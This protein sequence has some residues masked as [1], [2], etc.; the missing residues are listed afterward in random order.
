MSEINNNKAES[1]KLEQDSKVA[2]SQNK[3]DYF[4]LFLKNDKKALNAEQVYSVVELT[5]DGDFALQPKDAYWGSDAIKN[6][7]YK[8]DKKAFDKDYA[9]AQNNFS[10]FESVQE[11]LNKLTRT[12]SL[13]SYNSRSIS[14]DEYVGRGM[15]LNTLQ[16]SAAASKLN[17][18]DWQV[19]K[20]PTVTLKKLG[21]WMGEKLSDGTYKDAPGMWEQ[22][23]STDMHRLARTVNEDGTSSLKLS[24]GT[25][26]LERFKGDEAFHS[27]DQLLSI[28]NS[29]ILEN[30]WMDGNVVED[31]WYKVA[32]R[33]VHKVIPYTRVI[34]FVASAVTGVA[35][36][37]KTI[38]GID[39]E[40]SGVSSAAN[41]IQNFI[42]KFDYDTS[43]YAK[44]HRYSAES[45]ISG[46]MDIV[47][48][49]FGMGAVSKGVSWSAS[50]L[51]TKIGSKS[52]LKN[53]GKIGSSAGKHS[54][55]LFAGE[56]IGREAKEMGLDPVEAAAIHVAFTAF[57]YTL[58]AKLTESILG[59][60][61]GTSLKAE[62][63]QIQRDAIKST[64]GK[65][66]DKAVK[67]T[68]E[69]I[70]KIMFNKV[71]AAGTKLVEMSSRAGEKGVMGYAGATINESLEESL[72]QSGEDGLKWLFNNVYADKLQSDENR[73][74]GKG[75][76]YDRTW[77]DFTDDLVYSALL[78]GFGGTMGKALH[79]IESRRKGDE[80]KQRTRDMVDFIADPELRDKFEKNL[81]K[82][83]LSEYGDTKTTYNI[84]D[85]SV[86]AVDPN[87]PNHL[88]KYS[89][90]EINKQAFMEHYHNIKSIYDN[91]IKEVT[92]S[93]DVNKW[94]KAMEGRYGDQ[95]RLSYTN[96]QRDVNDKI[97]SL[98]D[99]TI[100][101]DEARKELKNAKD[102]D[103]KN[104]AKAKLD[105][106]NEQT[107]EIKEGIRKIT[108][109][110][111]SNYYL[112]DAL[113]AVN[114]SINISE[115]GDSLSEDHPAY[116]PFDSNDPKKYG[117]TQMN[118]RTDK[119]VQNE[120]QRMSDMKE[121]SRDITSQ[122]LATENTDEINKLVASGKVT[123]E[124]SKKIINHVS[125][126]ADP[127]FDAKK[128]K[129]RGIV[130]DYL[131]F[132]SDGPSATAVVDG[133]RTKVMAD[134]EAAKT[135]DDIKKIY[136]DD[137]DELLNT[138]MLTDVLED[139]GA[140]DLNTF[141]TPDLLKLNK[142][143]YIEHNRIDKI[144]ENILS[145]FDTTESFEELFQ[146][147]GKSAGL[148]Y[149][150][151]H[152]QAKQQAAEE[153][154]PVKAQ[155]LLLKAEEY[156]SIYEDLS[157]NYSSDRPEAVMESIM[158]RVQQIRGLKSVGPNV[159]SY[160]KQH[161]HKIPFSYEAKTAYSENTMKLISD[162]EKSSNI[163]EQNKIF[164]ELEKSIEIDQERL[165]NIEKELINLYSTFAGLKHISDTNGKNIVKN[166]KVAA[167]KLIAEQ[168]KLLHESILIRIDSDELGDSVSDLL[169]IAMNSDVFE[170][171]Y[172]SLK[173]AEQLINRH[174]ATL[175]QE[176]RD[177]IVSTFPKFAYGS[178][179]ESISEY[180][181][182][183]TITREGYADFHE[184]F[185]E[186]LEKMD[187]APTYEQEKIIAQ[188]VSKLG[189]VSNENKFLS[190]YALSQGQKDA[191]Q[192]LSD[193][194]FLDAVGGF[195]KT[196]YVAAVASAVVV[197]NIM[198]KKAAQDGSSGDVIVASPKVEQ[199]N[200]L[201]AS[202]EKRGV[203][204]AVGMTTNES[205]SPDAKTLISDLKDKAKYL[206][207]ASMI[208]YDEATYISSKDA[209][210]LNRAIQE[211]NSTE[212]EGKLPLRVLLMG[213]TSQM[214]NLTAITPTV[215][216]LDNVGD[217]QL[218]ERT[219]KGVSSQRSSNYQ[220]TDFQ[221][222][223]GAV[224][225]PVSDNIPIVG[226]WGRDHKGELGGF[227]V[228]T[229]KDNV[230][231]EVKSLMEEAK[232]AGK[233]FKYIT[234]K[235]KTD[236][237]IAD[238]ISAMPE[239]ANM[240]YNIEDVQGSEADYVYV[241]FKNTDVLVNQGPHNQINHKKLY[242]A[243][244]RAHDFVMVAPMGN[245]KWTSEQGKI[246][247]SDTRIQPEH[248]QELKDSRMEALSRINLP[249]KTVIPE[250]EPK[251]FKTDG[252]V[253]PSQG[254]DIRSRNKY[255]SRLSRT[256][257]KLKGEKSEK[258]LDYSSMQKP[259]YEQEYRDAFARYVIDNNIESNQEN[260][261]KFLGEVS[262][263]IAIL[264][265]DSGFANYTD[266]YMSENFPLLSLFSD[267]V[268]KFL[269]NNIHGY[270]KLNYSVS[271]GT[272]DA[273]TLKNA[274]VNYLGKKGFK[275]SQGTLNTFLKKLGVDVE[276]AK[277]EAENGA[278]EKDL[279]GTYN[280]LSYFSDPFKT[281]D[282]KTKEV[283]D[284]ELDYSEFEPDSDLQEKLAKSF[285]RYIAEKGIPATRE[286]LVDFMNQ[287]DEAFEILE[288]EFTTKK[289]TYDELISRIPIMKY[290]DDVLDTLFKDNRTE[291]EKAADEL[292]LILD[293][294][295]S[296]PDSDWQEFLNTRTPSDELK[297]SIAKKL[298]AGEK[299]APREAYIYEA[300]KKEINNIAKNLLKEPP[301]KG[302]SSNKKLL[303]ELEDLGGANLRGYT[304]LVH[305]TGGP[306][307]FDEQHMHKKAA[308]GLIPAQTGV[309]YTYT[310]K[311]SKITDHEHEGST[312]IHDEGALRA[313]AHGESAVYIEVSWNGGSIILGRFPYTNAA[314]KINNPVPANA[315]EKI[316]DN[317]GPNGLDIT[318][319]FK[320]GIIKEG[321]VKKPQLDMT[322]DNSKIPLT[323][324]INKHKTNNKEA[325]P[326]ISFSS[327][328]LYIISK[329]K[330]KGK[331][332]ML[333]SYLPQAEL[334]SYIEKFKSDLD[335]LSKEVSYM[336]VDPKSDTFENIL[337]FALQK[338]L[339]T[340]QAFI[341]FVMSDN[342]AIKFRK[343]LVDISE[344]PTT[345]K[346][347]KDWVDKVL[348]HAPMAKESKEDLSIQL[349]KMFKTLKADKG[350]TK[351]ALA[352]LLE[353]EKISIDSTQELSAAA[354]KVVSKQTKN[355][356]KNIDRNSVTLLNSL[357][358]SVFAKQFGNKL[359]YSSIKSMGGD[360]LK[361][362]SEKMANTEQYRAGF[363]MNIPMKKG[364]NGMALAD[365]KEL[366]NNSGLILSDIIESNITRIHSPEFSLPVSLISDALARSENMVKS[367]QEKKKKDEE[368]KIKIATLERAFEQINK[369]VPKVPL[370]AG[371]LVAELAFNE[372]VQKSLMNLIMNNAGII[373]NKTLS[374]SKKV[375]K[376]MKEIDAK[377]ADLNKRI[378]EIPVGEGDG[379]GSK[380]QN[381]KALDDAKQIYL[382]GGLDEVTASR[383]VELLD[384]SKNTSAEFSSLEADVFLKLLTEGKDDSF[385]DLAKKGIKD[386]SCQ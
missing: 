159:M 268:N 170:D 53:S 154:D 10:S 54:M 263:E 206:D 337:K 47:P 5:E 318:Q 250:E 311:S 366:P 362:L 314:R 24:F 62:M 241:D 25:P 185:K 207:G 376:R 343:V 160:E 296:I 8:G 70:A 67:E 175:T 200:K 60:A 383:L 239:I 279:K 331:V 377:I 98:A 48:Q 234:D 84:E 364:F 144:R 255:L 101:I 194:I 278:T 140:Q 339:M 355:L 21:I 89:K 205:G 49:I 352:A 12:S 147:E 134:I 196:E 174:W 204:V 199:F 283:G 121:V 264:H 384:P 6:G 385:L 363:M 274:Y 158:K 107:A 223:L 79:T 86:T 286:N 141:N 92:G 176:Q 183:N 327:N 29:G 214:G 82:I 222:K 344:D 308:L 251:K 136:F 56:D 106:L 293:Q 285:Q 34:P 346:G 2:Q 15:K 321:R 262:K 356:I 163:E 113:Y 169:D 375:D 20:D 63:R 108:S 125:K 225:A 16:Q 325:F 202:L 190:D 149:L 270:E 142:V 303:D 282:I 114:S 78:G 68:P 290:L 281:F 195:G 129:I 40:N 135:H 4:A 203:P 291:E 99:L 323:V 179:H 228:L 210:E 1:E 249:E 378:S 182:F 59:K 273:T 284:E 373:N 232:E 19:E 143:D 69:G 166:N 138:Q 193:M 132:F 345:T 27:G 280:F 26:Y 335:N 100:G 37:T 167:N 126:I 302:D 227:R 155:E 229:S 254:I 330:N 76:F 294:D 370:I 245:R 110:E 235:K 148:Q 157:Q 96:M 61:G 115:T 209:I 277:V 305:S 253:Y 109:G 171:T 358:G 145:D 341:D 80:G 131:D 271:W 322:S 259:E 212:R 304:W 236:T 7:I 260:L 146:K 353:M 105:R 310:L 186:A 153:T 42:H 298:N 35:E 299:L 359:L 51:A 319:E 95:V 18:V 77:G 28:F 71:K 257:R 252:R 347:L 162:L 151:A 328:K 380:L 309:K 292:K 88:K 258:E 38:D 215:S 30:T 246:I 172:S 313:A 64:L 23:S 365:A 116:L 369:S 94:A 306:M 41:Y 184:L 97:V 340:Q 189:T 307:S 122:I 300:K 371:D 216:L 276:A 361:E 247:K 226:V 256:L 112:E 36:M 266:K 178:S 342:Q 32:F 267:P 188:I 221:Q 312:R 317:L 354:A 83:K 272:V 368:F 333:Y 39:G 213:D 326:P 156:L 237:D 244:T 320:D 289:P 208:I 111:L 231:A 315:T 243:I 233:T 173:A 118:D 295:T 66:A 137:A 201:K 11:N 55:A 192:I 334:D 372:I 287:L 288:K 124:D 348:S 187:G 324:L 349:S 57:M 220:L 9:D 104:E 14:L 46:A 332:A 165:S 22:L 238:L 85:G 198:S 120:N 297:E 128:E 81:K 224:I 181:Y 168:A 50:K 123:V 150:H 197:A 382:D 58:P 265:I 13:P 93:E 357:S 164:K 248:Y 351:D 90:A 130:N 242:T 240:I 117:Y 374:I 180:N 3:S 133:I 336:I 329:G 381:M 211:Y 386:L 103:S 75:K 119:Y 73:T 72:E 338:G 139:K 152:E 102:E 191:G 269:G 219:D 161:K 52:M 350:L 316:I 177:D 261:N 217:L 91:T 218:M 44:A 301:K 17:A 31:D 87:S 33:N 275:A 379:E 45:L 43:D 74:T 360:L 127:E 230:A 65:A 367:E